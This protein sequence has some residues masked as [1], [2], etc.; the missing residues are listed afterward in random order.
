MAHAGELNEPT[1]RRAIAEHEVTGLWLTAGLFRTLTEASPD[2]L[3]GLRQVWVSGGP[4]GAAEACRVLA[5]CPDLVVMSAYA[6]SEGEIATC[7]ALSA[8]EAGQDVGTIGRPLDSV[9]AYVLDAELRPV[10]PGIPG[11]LYLAGA[12]VA[13]G[14][15]NRPGLTAE[16]FVAN[17]FGPPGARM[18]RSGDLARWRD[19]GEP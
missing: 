7:H 13:R 16:R 3:A 18:Y 2:C 1:L 4:V 10:P 12:A 5:A 17:P 6:S 11:E 15:W 14:Y 8:S 19:N 9:R